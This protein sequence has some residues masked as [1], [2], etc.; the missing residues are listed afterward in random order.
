MQENDRARL[1]LDVSLPT[2]RVLEHQCRDVTLTLKE[3]KVT[4]LLEMACCYDSL[5]EE[6]EKEKRQKHEELAADL[7]CSSRATR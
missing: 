4:L 7:A 1:M 6:R 3:S 2:N 5:L